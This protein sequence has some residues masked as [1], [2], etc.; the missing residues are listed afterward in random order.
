MDYN[1]Y[2]GNSNQ[3]QN[4][5]NGWNQY[6]GEQPQQGN[7]YEPNDRYTVTAP[8]GLATGALVL[9]ILSVVSVCCIYGSWI[10]GGI[11]ITLG[12]LSRGKEKKM[13]TNAMV[14]V[15]TS[16]VGIV[17]SVVVLAYS[18]VTVVKSFGDNG[19]MKYLEEYQ[20]LLEEETDLDEDY[21]DYWNSL[22]DEDSPYA[23]YF[24]NG[25]L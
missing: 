20:K 12:L 4:S 14:G 15:I 17:L 11:G 10:F 6:N 23:N 21:W 2:D 8:N 3:S 25:T 24:D 13:S 9:G 1:N 16:I 18:I 5:E 7:N 22:F 19:F